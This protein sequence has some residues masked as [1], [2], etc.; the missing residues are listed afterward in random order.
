M[1]NCKTFI[2]KY[3]NWLK[4]NFICERGGEWIEITTPFVDKSNDLIQVYMK[5]SEDEIILTDDGNTLG[6]LEMVGVNINTERRKYELETILNGFGATLRG[7]EIVII[8][9]KDEFPLYFN[10]MIQ[11]ILAVDAFY[12]LSQHRVRSMFWEDV[13]IFFAKNE[14]PY[15]RRDIEGKSGLRHKFLEIW[16]PKDSTTK[17]IVRV[18]S[19]P[20]RNNVNSTI[21]A[22]EDTKNE[23]GKNVKKIAIINDTEKKPSDYVTK[24]LY[25]YNIIPLLWSEREEN[26]DILID[27]EESGSVVY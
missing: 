14:I 11:A 3:I 12:L 24:A 8:T 9:N 1:T 17:K 13:E 2:D 4:E 22:F 23:I 25:K 7:K 6:N 18:I 10:N 27:R 5:I 15:K 21:F 16:N 20:E 19:R 26:I